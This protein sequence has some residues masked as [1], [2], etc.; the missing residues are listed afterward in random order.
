MWLRSMGSNSILPIV[1]GRKIISN[2]NPIHQSL[3]YDY[4][5]SAYRTRMGEPR[6]VFRGYRYQTHA[7][8]LAVSS[9]GAM[10]DL[11]KTY[12]ASSLSF[13]IQRDL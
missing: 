13:A 1:N 2:P 7:S 5:V 8:R 9:G 10:V 6:N 3:D 11:E 12:S 4:T